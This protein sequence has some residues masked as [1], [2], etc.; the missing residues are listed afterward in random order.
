MR[1][2]LDR[3]RLEQP[4]SDIGM[5]AAQRRYRDV[6]PQSF[7][8]SPGEGMGEEP[9]QKEFDAVVKKDRKKYLAKHPLRGVASLGSQKF[10]FVLDQ[11][12]EK[13]KRYD[14]LYFDLNGNGDLTDDRP[15]DAASTRQLPL[16]IA[17]YSESLFPRVD[18]VIDVNGKKLNYSFFFELTSYGSG[19]VR[20]VTGSLTAATYWRGEIAVE[21]KKWK[22][23]VLI[24]TATA[25]STT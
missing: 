23:A 16:I 7:Q 20:F 24:I 8:W 18:L 9:Y 12:D 21:G 6:S 11:K 2:K 3:V 5:A 22:V 25:A 10:G 4:S 19:D 13:S 14:R 17:S 1:F 15:I